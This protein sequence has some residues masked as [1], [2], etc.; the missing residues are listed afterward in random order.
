MKLNMHIEIDYNGSI[1]VCKVKDYM[2]V[3]N[4][5][6]YILRECNFKDADKMSQIKALDAFRAIEEDYKRNLKM[7]DKL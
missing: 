3:A 6:H 4:S 2:P 7:E 5:S 1:A